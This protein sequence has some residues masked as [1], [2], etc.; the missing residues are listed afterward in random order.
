MATLLLTTAVSSLGLTGIP[1]LAATLAAT[2]AGSVIDSAIFGATVPGTGA[3]L[4]ELNV[5]TSS[6]GTAVKRL[7]GRGRLGGNLIWADDFTEHVAGSSGGKG[8]SSGPTEYSYTV[9]FAVAFCEGNSRTT[10]GRVW[11]DSRPIDIEDYDYAFYPGSETQTA[12]PTMEGI[13][14]TGEVPAYRGVAY[15]V[16]KDLP[17][18]DFGNRIPSITAEIIRP[19][20]N[21]SSDSL[22][23][24]VQG[25]NLIPGTGEALYATEPASHSDGNGNYITEN[26]H[27][28]KTQT[29]LERSMADLAV[30]LPNVDDVNLVVSWFGTDLRAN[31]CEFKPKVEATEGRE[32][33]P[34]AW[35]VNGITRSSAEAV[36]TVDDAP[37]FGGTPADWTIVEAIQQ[38]CDVDGF[39]VNFYPFLL[40]D[41]PSGNTLPNT[42][43]GSPGQPVYPWRGRI[44]TS[45]PSVDKTASAQTEVNALFG[46]VSGSDF[47]ASGTTITYSGSAS[48]FGYRR[49]ILHYAHLCAATAN[50]LTDSSK[51]KTF[52]IGTELRGITRIRSTASGTATASTIYPGVNALV[53]LLEDVR[54]VFDSYGL[55]SVQLSYAADWSEYHS[56]RPSDGSGDVYFNMDAIWGHTDCDYVAIDNYMKLSDWRDGVA[57]EDYGT[58]S[59]TAYATTGTFGHASFPQG[60]SVYDTDY[61]KGQVEGG[62]DYD[63]YYASDSDRESQVRTTIEDSAYDEHWVYRQK[64]LRNWWEQTHRSRP[65]GTRDASVVAL[66]DGASGSVNT[67][68]ASAKKMAFSEYGC[69]AIDRGTNQPNV[70]YDAKS[71]ESAL[72]YFSNGARDDAMLRAYYEALLAYWQDNSP[73]SPITMLDLADMWAWT[74]D[75]RPY[76]AFPYKEDVWV[77]GVN[78]ELG[79]WLP[80]RVG[81]YTLAELVTEICGQV[82]LTSSDLDVTSLRSSSATVRGYVVDQLATPRDMLTPLFQAYLFDGLESVGKVKFVL[83][84][85]TVFTTVPLDNLV[86]ANNDPEGYSITRTQETELPASSSISFMDEGNDY[87]TGSVGGNRVV[88][89]SRDVTDNRFSLV[90]TEGYAR[91]LSEVLIQQQ[92]TAREKGE[93]K[94]PPSY[95]DLDPGDGVSV[96]VSGRTL[97]HRLM[98]MDRGRELTVTSASHDNSVFETLPFVGT[99]NS[100]GDI[101]VYG[102]SVLYFM[103]LPLVTGEEEQ[104]WAPRVMAYQSPFPASVDL[105]RDDGSSLTLNQQ[106]IEAATLGETTAS[107]SAADPWRF[108]FD[109]TLSVK[110]YDSSAT[111]L[112]ADTKVEV[113]NGANVVAVETSAGTWEVLQFKDATLTGTSAEGLPLYDLTGLLRGQLG[114]ETE[115][116]STLASGARFAVLKESAVFS[117]DLPQSLKFAALDYA[118]GPN[119]MD[120]GG[121]AFTDETHTGQATGLLP[122]APTRLKKTPTASSTE[123]TFTW[124]RRTR[125]GGDDFDEILTPLNEEQELYDLEIYDPSGPTLLRTVSSLSSPTYTYTTAAQSSDGGALDSYLIKVWQLSTT[126]GRGR[127]A[128]ATL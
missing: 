28:S 105:Y 39:D 63:Y 86:L 108:D 110:L 77:D 3:R 71:S 14:G 119:G 82:G 80:G 47:S 20:G 52:Y 73:T 22:E 51:F 98:R 102:A 123:V 111:L 103:D 5:M 59:V 15:L 44:T 128:Q 17:L 121:F 83:R 89:S 100:F 13:L 106:V 95:L 8:G 11:A 70:F 10:L 34:T 127:T 2:V 62:E 74:W 38:M 56:H 53:A 109:N 72:P 116:E 25:V 55:T 4:T 24:L 118:Y 126:V 90:L 124:L 87:Q 93:W 115:I 122:Y 113:L 36:S 69:P 26:L 85:S 30:Q 60:T 45:L 1:A 48:D 64:D 32:T 125:F 37:A 16:F 107:L 19:I 12:D 50:S 112:S 57:H 49:F 42:D 21:P 84:S 78:Y 88:G 61:L 94:L 27:T 66:N 68:S 9:S 99:S 31:N 40:M 120:T 29:D 101:N 18:T 114:T 54:A 97:E 76:P 117:V 91:S 81:T 6:E 33:S 7:Y 43:D 67:W 79:H 41:I 92:W 46:S 65:G 58:G 35:S 23:S 104:P 96:E 75:V